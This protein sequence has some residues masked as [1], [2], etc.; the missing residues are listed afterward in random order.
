MNG[1]TRAPATRFVPG[2]R[3]A[4]G[5]LSSL[6]GS[7][8]GGKWRAV[9]HSLGTVLGNLRDGTP[10]Q[11]PACCVDNVARTGAVHRCCGWAGVVRPKRAN[12]PRVGRDTA[13]QIANTVRAGWR[14]MS[15]RQWQFGTHADLRV[16]NG[17]ERERYCSDSAQKRLFRWHRRFGMHVG[18]LRPALPMY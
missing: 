7:A 10:A 5:Y 2:S 4:I 1:Q 12:R 17:T 16:H 18:F 15:A 14:L 11:L 13:A 9:A 6:C 8:A 3:G